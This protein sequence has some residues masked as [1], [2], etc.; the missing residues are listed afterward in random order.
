[1]LTHGEEWDRI[2]ELFPGRRGS[3]LKRRWAVIPPQAADLAH[4]SQFSGI[5]PI[6]DPRDSAAGHPGDPTVR[7]EDAPV[8]AASGSGF[9]FDEEFWEQVR[10]DNAIVWFG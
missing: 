8:A 2:T 1:V 5:S 4:P 9:R 7:E 3:E 6:G 10:R